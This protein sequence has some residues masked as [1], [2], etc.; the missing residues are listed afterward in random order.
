[1]QVNFLA[2]AF[3]LEKSRQY[4]KYFA[5][6]VFD[7]TLCISGKSFVSLTIW[8]LGINDSYSYWLSLKLQLC[9]AFSTS[10]ELSV[11]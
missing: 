8:Y 5:F 7:V 3:K 6:N 4:F 10:A 9:I 2:K 1:M 11:S